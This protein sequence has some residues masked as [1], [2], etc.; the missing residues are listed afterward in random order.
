[1]KF[2][3]IATIIASD[4]YKKFAGT[5]R[6]G[7]GEINDADL[8]TTDGTSLYTIPERRWI[9]LAR[10]AITPALMPGIVTCV[11]ALIGW[12]GK[13]VLLHSYYPQDCRKY[14][15]QAT[16]LQPEDQLVVGLFIAPKGHL[17]QR[18]QAAMIAQQTTERSAKERISAS[19]HIY[20]AP[21]TAFSHVVAY[22]GRLHFIDTFEQEGCTFPDNADDGADGF[23]TPP[24]V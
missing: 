5:V 13:Q 22:M 3:H 14:L 15:D 1:M 4:E 23:V 19:V 9:N 8:F 11:P 21:P 17:L 12:A 16:A 20:E 10:T 18:E 6:S 24:P 2:P 7:S